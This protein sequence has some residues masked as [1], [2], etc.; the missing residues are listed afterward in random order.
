MKKAGKGAAGESLGTAQKI[1]EIIGKINK[2]EDGDFPPEFTQFLAEKLPNFY[3]I[4]EY[5]SLE[6][7]F[8]QNYIVN[9]AIFTIEQ[10]IQ[11]LKYDDKNFKKEIDDERKQTPSFKMIPFIHLNDPDPTNSAAVL[12]SLSGIPLFEGLASLSA[13][14][15]YVERDYEYDLKRKDSEIKILKSQKRD[16]SRDNIQFFNA[17]SRGD[18]AFLE[19]YLFDNPDDINLQNLKGYTPLH[20]AVFNKNYEFMEFLLKKHAK[21]DLKTKDLFTGTKTPSKKV[22]PLHVAVFNND[23]YAAKILISYGASPFIQDEN[24]KSPLHYASPEMLKIL[25]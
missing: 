2:E 11:F 14:S 22:T 1:R 19:H 4:S 20:F 3:E 24:G 10:A 7:T 25:K 16:P 23:L 18:I 12:G 9:Q 6:F 5:Y 17:C 8:F 15:T 21:L 13:N